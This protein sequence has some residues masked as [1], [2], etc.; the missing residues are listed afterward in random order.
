MQTVKYGEVADWVL[1]M[2]VVLADGSVVDVGSTAAKTSSGYNLGALF[3]GSEGTLGV[4]TEATLELAGIPEQIRGGRA[5]F[6][7]YTDA[8]GAVMDAVQSGVDVAKIELVDDLA[9][10]MANAYLDTD[11]PDDPMVFV[12]FQANHGIETEIDFCRTIFEAHDVAR[13]EMADEEH[14]AELWNAREEIAFALQ[15]YDPDRKPLH[16]GDV[17]VPISHYRDLVGYV[18]DRAEAAGL[19]VPCFGHAGD[20]NLHYSVIVDHDDPEM[21]ERGETVYRD[22]VEYAIDHGG[23]A[24]GEHGIGLGKR[25]F[26]EHEHGAGTVRTMRAIKDTLDPKGILNPGK[27]FPDRDRRG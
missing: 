26:M 22:V 6:E 25:H 18:K 9:A 11:L 12:E 17:T 14:M 4:V 20:G 5:I 2:E 15:S 19:D 24:T 13:F 23:T 3:V 10:T 8:A 27:I 1:R 7:S 16:P 21:V